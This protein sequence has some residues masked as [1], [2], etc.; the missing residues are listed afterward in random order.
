MGFEDDIVLGRSPEDVNAHE[1]MDFEEILSRTQQM[2]QSNVELELPEMNF[3]PHLPLT[4]PDSA[5]LATAANSIEESQF[6]PQHDGDNT[7]AIRSSREDPFPVLGSPPHS[8]GAA[9]SAQEPIPTQR[10]HESSSTRDSVTVG[11]EEAATTQFERSGGPQRTIPVNDDDDDIVVVEKNSSPAVKKEVTDDEAVKLGHVSRYTESDVIVISDS[12]SDMV[13]PTVPQKPTSHQEAQPKL[14]TTGVNLGARAML[15]TPNP[16][17]KRTP[18]QLAKF[19]DIQKQLAEQAT[20]KTITGGANSIF[21]GLQEAAKQSPTMPSVS[22]SVT[23]NA[24]PQTT[25]E[26]E[27]AWMDIGTP[28]SDDDAAAAAT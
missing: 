27:N 13:K 15:R 28:D 6:Q 16:K 1:D 3:D 12:D 4:N 24:R 5:G 21:G 20:G 19:L 23:G 7:S 8:P 17:G 14:G 2:S 11:V 9:T 18:A 25:E 26:D 10:S 22:T